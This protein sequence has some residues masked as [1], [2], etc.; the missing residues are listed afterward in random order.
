MYRSFYIFRVP[1]E[2]VAEFL[3]INREAGAIYREHGALETEMTRAT[4]LDPKY[5]CTGLVDLLKASD[6][7]VVFVGVDGFRDPDH[8]TEVMAKVDADPRINELFAEIQK[9]IDLST[10]VRAELES[11]S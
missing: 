4:H 3:R 10:V 8:H 2:H 5:G 6:E 9:V 1:K 11:V 7:E